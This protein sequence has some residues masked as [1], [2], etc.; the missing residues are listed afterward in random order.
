MHALRHV[1]DD[2]DSAVVAAIDARLHSVSEHEHD[3]PPS[4]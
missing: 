1:G 3:S 2:F 4:S